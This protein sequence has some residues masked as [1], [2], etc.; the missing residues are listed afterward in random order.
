[1]NY[2][3][4]IFEEYTSLLNGDI[5]KFNPSD[6]CFCILKTPS[7]KELDELIKDY[8]DKKIE[9][10]WREMIMPINKNI[11]KLYKNADRLRIFAAA[12]SSQR[13]KKLSPTYIKAD[14]MT[15]AVGEVTTS[16]CVDKLKV[17][18]LETQLEMA[19]LIKPTS[20][21]EAMDLYK[22]K[23]FQYNDPIGVDFINEAIKT[24][25]DFSEIINF[26]ASFLHQAALDSADRKKTISRQ[27]QSV[28]IRNVLEFLSFLHSRQIILFPYVKK[29]SDN[30]FDRWMLH[31][32]NTRHCE[33]QEFV[34]PEATKFIKTINEASL[35]TRSNKRL[36][37]DAK[38]LVKS[39]TFIKAEQTSDELLDRMVE[40]NES[41]LNNS[42]REEKDKRRRNS[43][44]N[45]FTNMVRDLF[46]AKHN[47]PDLK[48]THRNA[49][50]R[51]KKTLEERA[52]LSIYSDKMPELKL[53]T[54]LLNKFCLTINDSQIAAR[55]AACRYFLDWLSGLDTI[56][57]TP[58]EINRSEH[59]ND[60][61]DGN[62][63]RNHLKNNYS[64]KA[65][66][67]H[68]QMY[69]QFFDFCHD[70]LYKDAENREV[71]GSFVNPIYSNFDR[72][73]ESSIVGTT[74]KPIES[75]VMEELRE[76][77]IENDYAFPK[78]AF[79]FCYAHLTNH[80]TGKYEHNVFCPSVANLL[81][82]MLWI[83][84]RK[85]QGQLLDSGEGDDYVYDFDKG[86]MVKN[87]HV[88]GDEPNRR[89]G[90]L[91]F[92]PSGVLGITD[93]LGLHI[94]TNKTSDN[95]YD[96]PWVCDELL[97]VLRNQYDWL[98]K[99]SPYPELR[100]KESQ[101]QLMT[102]EGEA[103]SKKFYCLFR[104][105]SQSRANDQ[106]KSPA[107][108][109]IT[110]AW[111]ILCKEAENRINKK[112][113]SSHK[114]VILTKDGKP[115][116]SK[117]DIHTLRVSGITDLLD[118]GVPLGIVQ[119]FVAGHATY[120]MTLHYDNPSIAKVREYLE[121]AR[122]NGKQDASSKFNIDESE[123][124][125]YKNFL[126]I[127]QTY[128]QLDYTAYDAL[129]ENVGIILI[130]LS[131]I[132]P[133]ASC[134]EGGI[135]PYK[136]RP[137]PVPVGD[138][139]PSCPQ[140]RFWLTGPMFLLGQVIEGNQLIRK[141][142]K[143]V[144]AIDLIR[145]SIID[146]EDEGNIQLYNQLTG[147]ED[148]E[149]R[150]LSNMLSEWSERMKFYEAS[151]MKLESWK[152]YNENKNSDDID[153]PIP[154]LSKSSEEDIKYGFSESTELELTHFLTTTAEFLPEFMDS[155][156]TSVPDLEQAI[157]RF[158]AINNLGDIMFR[159]SD[160]Q[161]LHATNMMTQILISNIGA[162]NSEDLLSGSVDLTAFPELREQV[163]SFIAKS[164]DTLFR[165]DPITLKNIE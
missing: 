162:Q 112:L 125:E 1:M 101:G 137:A 100:G 59:I 65:C 57:K 66:N 10:T 84:L 117:F 29:L 49:S 140:C 130:K 160:E 55:I 123:L 111:G 128:A 21:E 76:L 94:T 143:K 61:S 17:T 159:I 98:K 40:I 119:K 154:M 149:L 163:T 165:L 97:E 91:Q 96:I 3:T 47:D 6:T 104:D 156:D 28:T 135:D 48:L 155:D 24:Q 31:K 75:R 82:L 9:V 109:V 83:P 53:W 30:S 153:A 150:I 148:R 158:M 5:I 120:V 35:A 39:S 52:D 11:S 74:R 60:Y 105:P 138:R 121:N 81:Y 108:H 144:S 56:P 46:N 33:Y 69:K 20:V 147:R 115:N 8:L 25:S 78:K 50:S 13:I 141:I 73:A 93:V 22:T 45:S 157:A 7:D 151:V 134:E 139:G 124:D 152:E 122:K 126:V 131:G 36:A 146:A 136:D 161:R 68:F 107:P 62:T 2:V 132:C 89:E 116:E 71:L 86:Q 118:K 95:P 110:K 16:K 27:H 18:S 127:N 102:T 4:T 32:N 133:G 99:Y 54:E 142:K 88:I 43:T 87:P 129:E 113:P 164:E 37:S 34:S 44:F 80:L 145:V 12:H 26:L 15:K 42:Q 106:F 72:F 70:T 67:R 114:R 103:N 58:L 41:K 14:Y 79:T 63:L 51:L 64:L 38:N 19:Q 92:L 77:I 90:L 85:I 23:S